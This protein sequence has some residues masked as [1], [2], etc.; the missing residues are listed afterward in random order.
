MLAQLD[1]LFWVSRDIREA[2]VG[3]FAILGRRRQSGRR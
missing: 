2:G 1:H 3:L